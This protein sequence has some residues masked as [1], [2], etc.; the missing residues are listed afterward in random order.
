MQRCFLISALLVFCHVSVGR[1]T[2]SLVTDAPAA[3]SF[4]LGDS[5]RAADIAYDV[6]DAAVVRIAAELLAGDI[7]KVTGIKPALLPSKEAPPTA[8]KAVVY[9]GTL[10][11]SGKTDAIL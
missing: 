11:H 5:G 8:S 6:S 4:P 7:E 1:A 9:A 2:E 10:G 3:E